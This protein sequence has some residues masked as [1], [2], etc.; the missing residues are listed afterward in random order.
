[1]DAFPVSSP[2]R[3][4]SC[5]HCDPVPQRDL[6]AGE[7]EDGP[8]DPTAARGVGV[9]RHFS[10]AKDVQNSHARLLP[11]SVV[12]RDVWE[13]DPKMAEETH[14]NEVDRGAQNDR[15]YQAPYSWYP[16]LQ[17]GWKKKR[18]DG[19]GANNAE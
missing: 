7:L 8:D 10:I 13:K 15:G 4:C 18:R 3:G 2:G 1:M 9:A 16:Q 14:D 12:R 17:R 6:R 5:G 11:K 19:S